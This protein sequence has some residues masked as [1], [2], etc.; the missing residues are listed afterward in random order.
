VQAPGI[1]EL[2]LCLHAAEHAD[3]ACRFFLVVVEPNARWLVDDEQVIV[4]VD[5]I[6]QQVHLGAL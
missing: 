3:D 5:R 4:L 2:T 6:W 1:A